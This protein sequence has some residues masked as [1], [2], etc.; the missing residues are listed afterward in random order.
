MRQAIVAYVPVLHSG[1][2]QLLENHPDTPL[3][4]LDSDILAD[5]DWLRKDLRALA[6]QEAAE[7]VIGWN[8][9]DVQV[10]S[11]NKLSK[12]FETYEIIMPDED[13][14]RGLV[15]KFSNAKITL[16]PIFLRWDRKSSITNAELSP[17]HEISEAKFDQ[18]MAELAHSEALRSSNIWRRVGA[19]IVKNGEV[20]GA[21]SNRHQPTEHTAW[22][23]GDVRMNFNRGVGI[24]MTTDMHAEAL[25][26]AEAAG[27]GESLAG[28]AL[29]LT[30]FPCPNCAMLAVKAGIKRVYYAEGYAVLDGERVL[31]A[32]NVRLIKVDMEL[33]RDRDD[34]YRPYP[35]KS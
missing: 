15:E 20:I 16:E 19:V 25:L 22:I 8:L 17:D 30:T 27:R 1:Y 3:F 21:S 11:K 28:A 23:D 29:Y 32:N 13:V 9:G 35:E 26:I 2:R 5:F 4:I 34:V 14:S 18:E 12:I 10:I 6:P 33:P 31:K 24:E 7:A